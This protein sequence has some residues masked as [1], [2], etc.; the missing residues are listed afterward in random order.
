MSAIVSSIEE[1]RGVTDLVAAEILCDDNDSSAGHGYVTGEVFAIAGVA[2]ITKAVESSS[3][4]HYYNNGPA[5]VVTGTG[6]DTLTIECSA[7]PLDVEA[8]LTGQVYKSATGAYIEGERTPKYFALGYKTQKTDGTEVWVWRYKCMIAPPDRNSN[9]KNAGTD[10]NGQT[11]TVTGIMTTHVFTAAGG[12]GVKGQNVDLGL[13]LADVSTF[14]DTVTTPDDLHAQ[15]A[16]T[17]T[18]SKD[19]DAVLPIVKRNGVSLATGA[20]IYA[21]DELVITEGQAEDILEVNSNS[22]SSGDIHIV[23]GNTT[24]TATTA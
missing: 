13:G 8:K 22:W 7:L 12:K 3:E 15:T 10:A 17:L 19:A 6:A 2:S 9:T 4:A 14:F 11:L 1:Y 18:I 24:V 16:Y 5:V 20:T 23:R 21:G